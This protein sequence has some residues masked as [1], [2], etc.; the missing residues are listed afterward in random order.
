MIRHLGPGQVSREQ[1][2]TAAGRTAPGRRP[3]A[4][5]RGFPNRQGT[6]GG[7]WLGLDRRVRLAEELLKS[8]TWCQMTELSGT[9]RQDGL[10]R[11]SIGAARAEQMKR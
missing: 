11:R 6:P 5:R 8:E 10:G 9:A 1:L 2:L 7:C 4:R 3:D